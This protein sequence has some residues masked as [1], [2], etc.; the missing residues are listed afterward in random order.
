MISIGSHHGTRDES[1][2]GDAGGAVATEW[3]QRDDVQPARAL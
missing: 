1:Y 3:A 2:L